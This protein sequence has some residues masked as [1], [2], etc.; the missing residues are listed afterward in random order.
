MEGTRVVAHNAGNGKERWSFPFPDVS[1]Y[2]EN[3]LA[4]NK[5]TFISMS[6]GTGA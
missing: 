2:F 3:L 4:E 5:L 1:G 6:P